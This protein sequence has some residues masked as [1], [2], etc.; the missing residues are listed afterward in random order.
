MGPVGYWR[1]EEILDGGVPNEVPDGGRLLAVG[2]AT[3][4]S[5]SGNNHSGALIQGKQMEHFQV[6]NRV[7]RIM[8]GDFSI[9]LFANFE[10]LQNFVLV[11]SMRYD[12]KVKGHSFILQSYASFR[13]TGDKGTGLHAVLRDPPAWDGGSGVYGNIQMRPQHWYH[14]AATREGDLLTI[15]LDGAIVGREIV[16][17]M[18][19]ECREI[20]VGRLNGN[21][22]QSRMEARGLV[23]HLDELVIFPRALTETELRKLAIRGPTQ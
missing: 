16:G 18:P 8:T 13:R 14:I 19:L 7:D 6:S 23:G 17:S 10:W 12:Q 4:S 3:I 1:F 22:S 20:F 21:A 9:G 11:S 5:E 2:S 15:Y